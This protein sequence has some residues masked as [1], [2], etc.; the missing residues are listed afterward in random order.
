MIDTKV[1]Q[2]GIKFSPDKWRKDPMVK[3]L[4]INIDK[5]L[6]FRK[7][8]DYIRQKTDRKM[9]LLKV[10]NSL[11]DVNASTISTQQ[12]YNQHWSTE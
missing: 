8:A 7:H 5:R 3:Y 10:L 9:N 1:M 11:S 6:K 4:G 12:L 2:L